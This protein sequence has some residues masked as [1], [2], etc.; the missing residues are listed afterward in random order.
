MLYT[1]YMKRALKILIGII[2][3]ILLTII[4]IQLSTTP[5]NDREWTIDQS[6]LSSADVNQNLITL[7][8]V[9]NF[10][11]ATTTV[12][13]PGY[14]D[15]TY[16]VN[17]LKKVWY[18]VSPFAGVPGSAHTFFS[19]E[20]ENGTFVTNSIEIRK[21]VGE[22]FDPFKAMFNKYEIMYVWADEKDTVKLRSNY[23]QDKVFIYPMKLNKDEI[24]KLFINMIQKTN[25][26]KTTPEF[27]NI[28]TN[29]CMT[30]IIDQ[31][32]MTGANKVSLWHTS[33]L[34]PEDSDFLF[35]EHG[36]L[37]TDLPMDKIRE[38]FL[39]NDRALK[40]ASSTDF[41]VKIRGEE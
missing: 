4:I 13:A 31:L 41:S 35:Y 39:I 29:T 8:N 28:V 14:Y 6:V 9:R 3:C 23:R 25:E 15:K 32:N 11:Y 2:I 22:S 26:L 18:V 7:H 38:K 17:K 1:I 40:F 34:L 27:Y 24:Q 16:D 30:N 10:E 19:F 36:L 37:D 5:S 20:F 33:V 12:F 21:E